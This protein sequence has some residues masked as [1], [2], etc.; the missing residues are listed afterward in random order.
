MCIRDRSTTVW[1]AQISYTV[2]QARLGLSIHNLSD[3]EYF[4]PSA[5]FGGNQVIPALPRT[6]VATANFSF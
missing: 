1:D 4:V 6:V 2:R 3:K 5:Y